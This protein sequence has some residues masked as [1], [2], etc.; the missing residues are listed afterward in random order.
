M[1]KRVISEKQRIMYKAFV[2]ADIVVV[3]DLIYVESPKLSRIPNHWCR[4]TTTNDVYLVDNLTH[5]H[6]NKIT[7]KCSFVYTRKNCNMLLA[8]ND[9][10]T[11]CPKIDIELRQFI[12]SG[13]RKIWVQIYRKEKFNDWLYFRTNDGYMLWS[14]ESMED[15][16]KSVKTGI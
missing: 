15:F 4:N 6:P 3:A 10:R 11:K 12:K 13:L 16:R 2:E 8:T 5:E 14:T 1:R 9:A 7:R